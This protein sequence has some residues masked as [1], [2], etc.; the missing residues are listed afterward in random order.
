MSDLDFERALAQHNEEYRQAEEFGDDWFP[1]DAEY[2]VVFA[3]LK[4]GA[5]AQDDSDTPLVWWRL[6]CRIDD[7]A[8]PQ[9][10]GREF[11]ISL[12]SRLW[13]LVKAQTRKLNGGQAAAT[14][15]EADKILEAAVG[16]VGKV[17]VV[18]TVSKKNGRE[19]TNAYVREMI[20]TTDGR[21]QSN[22]EMETP[23]ENSG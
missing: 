14:P 17:E 8:N 15:E 1:D 10:H 7:V 2:I 22:G 16:N 12:N 13:G 4:K 18:T 3:G 9:L 5:K 23:A 21:E 11:P 6:A 19:Y 20:A